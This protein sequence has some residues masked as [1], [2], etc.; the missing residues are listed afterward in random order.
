[1]AN[2]VLGGMEPRKVRIHCRGRAERPLQPCIVAGGE[3]FERETA[4]LAE[5]VNVMLERLAAKQTPPLGAKRE[6]G[7]PR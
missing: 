6:R 1:M 2:L 3:A 5:F 4:C 7:F